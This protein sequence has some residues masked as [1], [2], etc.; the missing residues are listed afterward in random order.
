MKARQPDHCG[1]AVND[2]V[3]L[4]YEVHGTGSTTVL[5]FPTWS[6]VDSRC[7]KMQVPYLSRRY[8]VVTYDPRGNGRS[9][10]PNDA[11]AYTEALAVADA[12][13]VLDA[14]DTDAAVLVAYCASTSRGL[15]L[16]RDH[17]E[18]AL[19]LAMLA[20]NIPRIGSI[21][22]RATHSFDAELDTD[23]GWARENRGYWKRNWPGYVEWFMSN[24][25][26][27]PHSTKVF[28]DMVGWGLQTDA[29]TILCTIDA[30]EEGE[31]PY[32]VETAEAAFRAL[33]CPTLTIVGDG[34]KIVPP[35]RSARVAELTDGDLLT[36]QGGG[37]VVQARHPVVVNH[38]IRDFIDRIRPPV[39]SL[40]PFTFARTRRRKALWISSPI[41][42]GHVLRDIAMARELRARTPDLHIDWL[43]QSPV[44]EML[45]AAGET[46]HPASAELASESAHW[47]SEATGHDL[48]AFYAF[49]RMDEILLANYMV[50]DDITR[51]TPY[52][53]WVGDE[54]WE[55]DHYLHENPERKTA[56]Y[57]FTTDV[58]GFLP[59]NAENDPQ[60]VELCADYNAEMI[61]HRARYPRLRDLSLFIGG[62]D[63]LP[64][65]SLGPGLPTVRDWTQ[66]WFESV[67][68]VVPYDAATY[69]DTEA[70]RGRLGHGVGYPLLVAA[71]G[72]T[73]V[74]VGLLELIA[75]G[76]RY[77]R[78]DV[79]DARMLMVT[80]PRIDPRDLPDVDGMTKLGFVPNLY[81][82]LAACD[83][84]IVQGGLSTTME[85][86]AAGRPFVYFPLQSHWEQRQF[87][88]HRLDTYGAGI[89]MEYA[90]TTPLDLAVSMQRAL[91]QPT[92]YRPVPSDG[93]SRAAARIAS[94]IER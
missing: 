64:D 47:E 23:D 27:E 49:R 90:D 16:A 20:P 86:V 92:R 13:T 91:K 72:G 78:K 56:P 3:R 50:F 18:R 26:S 44:T 15:L 55:I 41:G 17:P 66:D 35:E 2:G 25:A 71:V 40:T 32:D 79:S 9:D 81:E 42:L 37:H 59:V 11:Q 58:V 48:H 24:A 21:P 12:L 39:R 5:L 36:I 14:T 7:W 69:S 33:C 29:E 62:Y 87:V 53:L 67:P 83:A 75:E 85:L 57:V 38:A 34:D 88:A 1:Y 22:G 8:R 31:D 65:A 6:I 84:A 93:A 54:S 60:E 80:G 74:G 10:R 28:D 45:Q 43:A 73:A 61:E 89:R 52:D 51:E 63:E 68:Y 77:L 46:V 76:F 4:Y 94:L 30:E 19:G 82:H 70:L